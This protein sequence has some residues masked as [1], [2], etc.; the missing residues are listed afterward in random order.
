MNIPE[1]DVQSLIDAFLDYSDRDN[2]IR[3]FGAEDDY[4]LSNNLLAPYKA[5]NHPL[6]LIEELLMIRGFTPELVYG[7][8]D[9]NKN[10]QP[11]LASI[12]ISG[13]TPG[14]QI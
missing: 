7:Y 10:F 12:L 11:G 6:Y 5:K 2:L 3:P 4:Y 1:D 14:R 13:Q 9:E 8:L